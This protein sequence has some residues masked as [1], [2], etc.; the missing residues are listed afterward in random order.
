[1]HREA[2]FI[3]VVG[4]LAADTGYRID[5]ITD[6]QNEAVEWLAQD[7][8]DAVSVSLEIT[9][10]IENWAASRDI[11]SKEAGKSIRADTLD[12]LYA[13]MS[14]EELAASTDRITA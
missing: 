5:T 8:A 11:H 9:N 4:G 12:L 1:M 14:D 3:G 13:L 6:A 2:I 10:H 7:L